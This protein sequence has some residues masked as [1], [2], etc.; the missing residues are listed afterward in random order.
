MPE[1][2]HLAS[3][4]DMAERGGWQQAA[5]DAAELIPVPGGLGLPE[6]AALLHDGSTAVGLLGEAGSSRASTCWSPRPLV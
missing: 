2:P 1:V 5:V 3:V 4:P 6:V